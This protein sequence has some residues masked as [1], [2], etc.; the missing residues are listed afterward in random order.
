MT[1]K[2]SYK[3]KVSISTSTIINK[4]NNALTFSSSVFFCDFIEWSICTFN[5]LTTAYNIRHCTGKIVHG[6]NWF[7]WGEKKL[8]SS[9]FYIF[10]FIHFPKPLRYMFVSFLW[11]CDFN[12]IVLPG[13]I[14][15]A[16]PV[17]L[18]TVKGLKAQR[19]CQKISI[20]QERI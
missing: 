9:A 8:S 10:I 7:V 6:N 3:L 12:I 18:L 5:F 15:S 1:N 19:P 14:C 11:W 13:A 2:A 17:S 20:S 16:T 4:I